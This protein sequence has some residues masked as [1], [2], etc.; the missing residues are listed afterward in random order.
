MIQSDGG[1]YDNR[2]RAFHF[3]SS[4]TNGI[5]SKQIAYII[6]PEVFLIEK[7]RKIFGLHFKLNLWAIITSSSLPTLPPTSL[8]ED[9]FHT[10]LKF[11]LPFLSPRKRMGKFQEFSPCTPGLLFF[12]F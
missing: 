4:R 1:V 3:L 8:V 10:T 11:S 12:F 6:G 9:W 5:S 7:E 2:L